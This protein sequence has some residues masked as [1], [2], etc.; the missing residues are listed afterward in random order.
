MD[1]AKKLQNQPKQHAAK[2]KQIAMLRRRKI[3][4]ELICR[5]TQGWMPD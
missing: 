2:S 5:H 3:L 1:N 4:K